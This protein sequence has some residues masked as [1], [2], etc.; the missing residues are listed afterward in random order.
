MYAFALQMGLGLE[1]IDLSAVLA[2][3]D[4]QAR[5]NSNDVGHDLKIT[6]AVDELVDPIR[7]VNFCRVI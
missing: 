6:F 3:Q 4:H 2:E 7:F 1:R 5:E